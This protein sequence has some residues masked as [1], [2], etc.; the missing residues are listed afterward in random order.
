MQNQSFVSLSP[1]ESIEYYQYLRDLCH[2]HGFEPNIVRYA[3]S[4][5][6]FLSSIYRNDEVVIC[7]VLIRDIRS[8]NI[9]RFPLQGV[10][11]GLIAVW[12]KDHHKEH[13]L[14]IIEIISKHFKKQIEENLHYN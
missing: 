12:K 6:N 8:E 4:A 13:L 3:S 5:S 7:D 2:K 1:I 10:E 9:H 14:D 11:S